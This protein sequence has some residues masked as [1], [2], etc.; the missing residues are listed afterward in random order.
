[1]KEGVQVTMPRYSP[2]I[3][4]KLITIFIF[5]KVLP[6]IALAWFAWEEIFSLVAAM[7][8]KTV[9]MITHTHDVVKGV[10]ELSTQN[11]IKALDN[12]SRE[13]I[14]RLT[15]DTAAAVA[16]FL[17]DRDRDIELAAQMPPDQTQ[18]SKFLASRYRPVMM[19]G[20]WV[21]NAGGDAW[22][23]L[24]P[25]DEK[26]DRIISAQNDENRHSFHYR[27]PDRDSHPQNRPLYLE[28]TFI[29]PAGNEIVKVDTSD[30]LPR[31]RRNVAD[32]ANTYCRAETYFQ[33]LKKL[34]PGEI[35]VSEIIGPYVKGRMIGTFGRV[36]AEK[37]GIAF[38]PEKSGYAG[39]E[40]PVGI[41]FRGLVRWGLPVVKNARII[42]YVTLALDHTHIMEFTDHIVPTEKRC[43]V[44]PDAGS[45][46]YAFMWDY[47]GRNISHPRD[48]FI[49][50]YD[51]RTGERAVPWMDEQM[52]N[53][54]RQCGGS[55][56]VFEQRAPEF[57]GQA[58]F[59]KP[60]AELTRDGFL[61]LDGRYL[62]FAPQCAGWHNLTREGGS[63]SFLIFWSGLW[64][65]TT[66]AAIPYHTG[67]YGN[68]PRGFGYVTIGANVGEFHRPAVETAKTIQAIEAKFTEKLEAEK[69]ADH[70]LMRSSLQNAF[71]N[72]T[73]YTALMVV[74]VILIAV[75]IAAALTGKITD[76]IHGIRRFQQ[77]DRDCRLEQQST[78]EMGQLA[79]AFNVMA[80]TVQKY[81]GDVEL[82]KEEIEKINERLKAE[83]KERRQAQV[84]LSAHRDN[85]EELVKGRTLAL[86]KEIV[87]R[88]RVEKIQ[89]ESEER[90][91]AQNKTLLYLTA[92]ESLHG[93]DLQASLEVIVPAAARTLRVERGSVW[94]LDES[95][96]NFVCKKM[97]ILSADQPAAG[98][99]LPLSEYP[100]LFAA[101]QSDRTIAASDA[102][103][104]RRLNELAGDY[105][106]D[107]DIASIVYVTIL[108][109]SE[110][111]G[112]VFFE[113]VREQRN[114]HID[115]QNFAN[116]IADMVGLALGSAKRHQAVKEKEQLEARLRR[117]EKMEAI[118][119][120][121]GGVAHD[122]NNILSGIVSYPELLLYRL[123][124]DSEMRKPIT[125]ILRSGK[126]AANI[127]QDLLTLARRG[128][129]I[130]EIV[131]LNQIVEDY[132]Q[133]PE[134]EKM[135]SFFPQVRLET[136]LEPDLMNIIG[137][138]VHLSKTLMNLVSNAAEAVTRQGMITISTLNCYIDR[139][140]K[141]YDVVKEGDYVALTVTDNGIGICPEDLNRIFE[142]FYTKKKMGRSGT[143]LGMAV[144]WGTV[145][146]HDGYIDFE[147]RQGRGSRFT[148][149]F[150]ITR[151]TPE[152]VRD[153]AIGAYMGRGETILVVD[154]I[155][156]QL[157]I[158]SEILTILGYQVSTVSSGE[159][160]VEYL[161]SNSVDLLVL[162]MIM[163]PGMDGLDT[164]RQ[165]IQR[166]PHQKAIISSGFSETE[167][168]KEV[169]NLGASKYLKKPYS[170]ESIGIAVQTVLAG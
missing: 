107:H 3:R 149:Y 65:L 44:I 82:S 162:D 168:I 142:P 133:S 167:R 33:A 49:S 116:S 70:A 118:G 21:L 130:T 129:A 79:R 84:E 159:K 20:Q 125:N 109:G 74:I 68:H 76:I 111:V 170:I 45:G 13:A 48:Y 148:L 58:L 100:A 72:L 169:L 113:Q 34:K 47:K 99:V 91:R 38:E 12:K 145:K 126:R 141:G 16:S 23:P 95:G 161:D 138:S 29:D 156:E 166:H 104:D 81:I 63:G 78:D 73:F 11:S 110:V 88:K 64:K 150:P 32:P 8:Q 146:D 94:L 69:K 37:K 31:A 108:E 14:E 164:Y 143:G 17:Y 26:A 15:T 139:P 36:Q 105:L 89:F 152:S 51:P 7:E 87:E 117:A 128:V 147:S 131:N 6:L 56:K 24:N 18:Y 25:P 90:L 120:L 144:V 153:K 136:E 112:A 85:L 9:A 60:A 137:S 19:P 50:G 10:T 154:D 98:R 46:N 2:G 75:F 40:N 66:A 83:I 53:L 158:A 123:P 54:W 55:M 4:A 135:V 42:G 101:L 57:E 124:A 103:A 28:M 43:S 77:G 106:P 155:Q 97:V 30:L 61:G 59:K 151:Q 140:I 71:K 165:V 80:D 115:E 62:N 96:V 114:W 134:H 67:I 102:C 1:M 121:A 127:V 160:A 163:K 22:V 132:L 39:K 35:Y 52:Y 41:R 92:H 157:E 5:I 122:L 119:T 93:G 86:E 27:K